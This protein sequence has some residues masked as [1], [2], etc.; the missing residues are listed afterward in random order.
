MTQIDVEYPPGGSGRKARPDTRGS[1]GLETEPGGSRPEPTPVTC[2]KPCKTPP[3][4]S[5]EGQ[6]SAVPSGMSLTCERSDGPRQASVSVTSDKGQDELRQP[7]LPDSLSSSQHPGPRVSSAPVGRA[8]HARQPASPPASLSPSAAARGQSKRSEGFWPAH[9]PAP[10]VPPR[11]R[12]ADTPRTRL[13]G[14]EGCISGSQ[15]QTARWGR[16]RIALADEPPH[17]LGAPPSLSTSMSACSLPRHIPCRLG[18]LT[19]VVPARP[20]LP[21]RQERRDRSE[22]GQREHF[23]SNLVA[24]QL[25]YAP[26]DVLIF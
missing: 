5:C 8:P 12:P 26:G 22:M 18:G 23:A 3:E 17:G 13:H 6:R 1:E 14:P 7:R 4:R 21:G 19:P 2:D 9:D 16:F 11:R 25:P 10:R 20:P 24:K 15:H